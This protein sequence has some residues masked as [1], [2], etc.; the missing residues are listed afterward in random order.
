MA[1]NN[2][3]IAEAIEHDLADGN[4]GDSPDTYALMA[5]TSGALDEQQFQRILEMKRA[6]DADAA[7]K[8]NLVAAGVSIGVSLGLVLGGA[9]V[10]AGL[11][12][13]A[14]VSL[15]LALDPVS[16]WDTNH[17]ETALLLDRG[18]Q[19]TSGEIWKQMTLLLALKQAEASGNPVIATSG[20][21]ITVEER[22]GVEV[23][24]ATDPSPPYG[25]TVVTF[26]HHH[27]GQVGD[28]VTDAGHV[29][30]EHFKDGQAAVE[31]I[32]LESEETELQRESDP[33]DG[34]VSD[35]LEMG[36]R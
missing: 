13:G 26:N 8:N 12:I 32:A 20:R 5:G 17:T 15:Y 33:T 25:K 24:I 27:D 36:G 3:L 1:G 35:W 29:I 34:V 10:V 7:L 21:I 19:R 30:H 2:R 9:P 6:V 18:K 28:T 23:I 14:E 4:F 22:D 31:H 11:A 16:I